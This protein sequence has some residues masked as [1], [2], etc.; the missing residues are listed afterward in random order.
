MNDK[1][2]VLKRQSSTA[3]ADVDAICAPATP[4]HTGISERQ[5]STPKHAPIPERQPSLAERNKRRLLKRQSSTASADVDAICAPSTPKHIAIPVQ[6]PTIAESKKHVQYLEHPPDGGWGWLVVL[7]SFLMHIVVIASIKS[8]GVFYPVFKEEFNEG[9]GDTAFIQSTLVGMTLICSPI[10]CALSKLTSCRLM[11]TTGAVL[12]AVGLIISSF[13]QS[14][15]YLLFSLGIVTGFAMSLMYSPC[16]TMV[17]RYFDKKR[18][19]ANGIGLSGNGVGMFALSPLYQVLIDEYSYHGALLVIAAI[20]LHGCV[21]GALLRPIRLREDLEQQ[22]LL[23]KNH[24]N[25]PN[26]PQSG[27]NKCVSSTR[28]VLEI[29]DVSLLT[30]VAFALFLV[31]H[32][33]TML[34]YSIVFVHMAKH[35]Q[36]I[37][38]GKTEASFLISVMGISEFIFRL[39]AGWFADL[40][41]ISRLN[42]YM[43]GAAGVGLCNLFVPFCRSY[44]SLIVYMAFYGLSSG[45]FHSLIAVLVREYTGVARL[46]NGIGWTLLAGGTAYLLGSP[47]AGWLYDATGNYNVSFFSAG[48]IIVTSLSLLCIKKPSNPDG[49]ASHDDTPSA[50]NNISI[51]DRDGHIEDSPTR[52]EQETTL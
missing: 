42:V 1:R 22:A 50:D 11:V 51:V 52:V 40:G 13:A 7:S 45:V 26:D 39:I 48:S 32:F 37:G 24:R 41:I 19:T 5:P 18:A 6:Q 20:T 27:C 34:G 21:C 29:F 2:K 17:G 25:H 3:A 35:A 10:A 15:T 12:A 47:I 31:S 9:A 43:I 8:F 28:K 44:A 30:D 38:V 33:G 14:V 23:S 46:F 16:L 36:N 4:K 49:T